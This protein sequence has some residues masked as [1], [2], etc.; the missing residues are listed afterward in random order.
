MK[1]IQEYIDE[2]PVWPDGTPISGAPMTNMQWFIWSL[3]AI[4][5]FFEGY[6]V[7]MTG[8]ALPLI[9]R[10]FEIGS[11]ENGLIGAA[12]LLGI[13]VG[14]LG[15]G[16]MSD[17]FGRKPMFIVEMLIFVAFLML[18]VLAS[19]VVSIIICLFGIGLALGCDYPTAHM[20]I[21]E[22]I[23]SISRG[24]L[25]LGAF[26]FQALGALAGTAV[27]WLVLS[28]VPEL[29]AW[30]W[31][32]ATAVIPALLVTIGRFYITESANWLLARGSIEP[33]QRAAARLLVRK[34]Q[35]PS[36][37]ELAQRVVPA[38]EGQRQNRG[39]AALFAPQNRRATIFASVPWFLQDLGTY[40]IGIFTPTILAATIGGPVEHVRSVSDL[41]S[42]GIVAA[43]GSALITMLLIVG[44]IFAVLLADKVGRISLQVLG[45]F[46]CA[47]GLLLAS[48]SFYVTGG[49]KTILIFAGFMLFNFMTNLGPNAQTYLLAGE[50]FPTQIRGIGAG[51][52][53]AVGKIGAV[54]TAF[55]FPILL[56]G[57]GTTALLYILVVTS[58][59]GAVVTWMF[60][61]ETTGVNL[62]EIGREAHAVTQDLTN[63]AAS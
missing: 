56:A 15:L 59:L 31:M 20:I 43:K 37:I 39:F 10:E 21:S 11:A 12:S 9:S 38:A 44:I 26:G 25:V 5:K 16:G 8:V 54:T 19:N 23:P 7:F 34:P 41:I 24:R 28:L 61:I 18:L 33:A 51:F 50:V 42:D 1:S 27:G 60:R 36:K 53:A 55:L 13:L 46:G 22:N 4:G 3:A 47:A 49:T 17:R 35:Y 45:F 14:A 57:I 30:R 62:A 40:G 32:Y 2:R 29:S 58:I 63:K 48:F 6:V 52:A